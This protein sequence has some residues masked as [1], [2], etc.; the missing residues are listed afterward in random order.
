M[1]TKTYEDLRLLL[2]EDGILV[3]AQGEGNPAVTGA[4]CDS[5]DVRPGNI[6][7]CKGAAFSPAYLTSAIEAGASC[8]LCDE[9]HAAELAEVAPGT[10]ALVSSNVRRAMGLVSA[11][12]WGRPDRSLPVVGITG[13][14][15][16]STVAYML[17]GIIDGREPYAHAGVMGS[18][19]TF[20]GIE[21]FESHNTT[22]EA[23]EMWRHI[24]NAREAGLSHMV[25]EVS[26]QGLKYDRVLD[27]GLKVA[28]FLNI[29]RDHISPIEHPDYEDYF[30]S[31]LRIFEQAETA[32]VNL[33]TDELDR[34]LEASRA[35]ERVVTFSATNPEA[36][37]WASDIKPGFGY[38]SFTAHAPTWEMGVMVGMSGLFNVDNALA[39][40]AAADV[41][42]IDRMQMADALAEARVPGRMEIATG[43]NEHVVG[44]VDYAHNKLS[45]QRFF[46]S[47]AK[48]FPDRLVIAVFGAAGDKAQER[49]REL[50]E[51]ASKWADL[52]IYTEEDPAHERVEDI[53]AEMAANTPAGQ[54]HIVICDREK[55]I[56]YAVDVAVDSG[57]PS[58]VC[59]LAKGDETRQHVG[60]EYP[61]MVPDGD[62]FARAMMRRLTQD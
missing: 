44:I 15:G 62:V 52:L 4:A 33:D 25:M 27:L 39:A 38:I 61:E 23:P 45:F 24:A 35:A 26:S 42:G 28:V 55:A 30:S 22:P 43:S 51:E 11:E 48:E 7:C 58:L 57:R 47:M 1:D 8:Y 46:S 56:E 17:R 60:D 12:A 21:S 37:Y 31:K 3:A 41:L 54:D 29:G 9:A 19:D 50:P 10:P 36:D 32:V 2:E 20:D 59:L 18:I 14:K 13:T 40:I 16:K 53:C 6:F 49:R 34:V 5:R